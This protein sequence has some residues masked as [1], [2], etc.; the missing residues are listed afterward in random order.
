MNTKYSLNTDDGEDIIYINIQTTNQ[1]DELK[2]LETVIN[3]TSYIIRNPQEYQ[4]SL[5]RF[6]IPTLNLPL[7]FFNPSIIYAVGLEFGV[8]D[9]TQA[10]VYVDTNV[11]SNYRFGIWS[12]TDLCDMIN[13]AISDAFTAIQALPGFP[14]FPPN[15]FAPYIQ[16]EPTLKCFSVVAD[17]NWKDTSPFSNPSIPRLY[18]ND[19]LFRLFNNFKSLNGGLGP[20]SITGL[21]DGNNLI[22]IQDLGNN[23][24][25]TKYLMPPPPL[26]APPA[27]PVPGF[28]MTQ[29]FSTV[30]LINSLSSIA[31][32]SV[33]LPV[34][35]INT[36]QTILGNSA[37]SNTYLQLVDDFQPLLSGPETAGDQRS[38]LE[39]Q[40]S[41][42]RYTTLVGAS[43]LQTVSLSFYAY[44]A[45]QNKYVPLYIAPQQYFSLR[46]MFKRKK[47]NF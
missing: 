25:N 28:I 32:T 27:T 3:R 5:I 7:W 46:L 13:K 15:T 11:G 43:P 12:Y 8:F 2:L 9:V 42:F 24:I 6:Q 19:N 47:L 35:Q 16:Y 36:T 20:F 14:G 37:S 41:I 22:E 30:Y 21:N 39:Y 10:L 40:P 17:S 23:R 44:L 26:P 18:F 4:L 34:T 45:D 29:D 38:I 31:I 33:D 1:S